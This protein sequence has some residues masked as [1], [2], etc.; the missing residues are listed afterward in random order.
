MRASRLPVTTRRERHSFRRARYGIVNCGR[1]AN[2]D[3][4]LMEAEDGIRTVI[5][6]V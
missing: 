3:F 6:F 5:V 1:G 4:E 2:R